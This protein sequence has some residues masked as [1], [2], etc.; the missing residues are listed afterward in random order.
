MIILSVI[1]LLKDHY[2]IHKFKSER[3]FCL[4]VCDYECSDYT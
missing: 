1:K 4:T 3:V 2:I